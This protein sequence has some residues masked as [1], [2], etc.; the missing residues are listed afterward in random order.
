MAKSQA[1]MFQRKTKTPLNRGN[2]HLQDKFT[3]NCT[4]L[5]FFT[6]MEEMNDFPSDISNGQKILSYFHL[7]FVQM[8]DGGGQIHSCGLTTML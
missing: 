5:C 4:T 7:I 8:Q 3:D 6:N 2:K 1:P